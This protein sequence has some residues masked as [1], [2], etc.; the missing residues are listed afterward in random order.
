MPACKR[1]PSRHETI[2]EVTLI[3]LKRA[4]LLCL[5]VSGGCTSGPSHPATGRAPTANTIT[6]S[7]IRGQ[8][9]RFADDWDVR[10][11]VDIQA[12]GP[13]FNYLQS[14]H[15]RVSGIGTATGSD[16]WLNF[17]DDGW[18]ESYEV[19][20]YYRPIWPDDER[21]TIEVTVQVDDVGHSSFGMEVYSALHRIEW[22]TESKYKPLPH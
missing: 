5:V 18:P 21:G 9:E 15:I 1:P 10:I 11:T 3:R 4:A 6:S 2:A 19:R 8:R 22:T 20:A 17:N 16:Y 12:T 14:S 7:V 13:A